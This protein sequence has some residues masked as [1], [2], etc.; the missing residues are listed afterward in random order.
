MWVFSLSCVQWP[1][2]STM[3]FSNKFCRSFI[4]KT[5][6]HNWQNQSASHPPG[7]RV[8]TSELEGHIPSPISLSATEPGKTWAKLVGYRTPGT[9]THGPP[10][11]H[12]TKQARPGCRLGSQAGLGCSSWF[13]SQHISEAVWN[14]FFLFTM[15]KKRQKFHMMLCLGI[16]LC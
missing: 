14:Q 11:R 12:R 3:N 13:G 7:Q 5:G 6:S 9:V 4:L 16:I 10:A 2:K 1:H 8:F 15:K